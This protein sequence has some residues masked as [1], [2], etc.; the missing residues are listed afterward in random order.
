MGC[1]HVGASLA[2]L[3]WLCHQVY[4]LKTQACRLEGFL[5]NGLYNECLMHCVCVSCLLIVVIGSVMGEG[6]LKKLSEWAGWD[7]RCTHWFDCLR[8]LF[9]RALCVRRTRTVV[10]V[11]GQTSLMHPKMHPPPTAQKA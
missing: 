4:P 9:H 5:V 8:E 10:T 11:S 7:S 2:S 6:L 3:A 1:V